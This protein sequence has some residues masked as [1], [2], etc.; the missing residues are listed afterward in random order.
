MTAH[1]APAAPGMDLPA[2]ITAAMT[3]ITGIW[4]EAGTVARLW[5]HDPDVW[6]GKDEA[7]WLGWLTVAHRQQDRPHRFAAL[8]GEIRSGDFSDAVVLGMGGSSLCPEVLAR[9]YPKAPGL[10]RLHVLDSTDPAQVAAMRQRVDLA[11][12]LFFVSSKSGTTL[13]PNIFADYF[14]DQV[15]AVVGE[16]EAARRFAAITDPGS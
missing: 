4:R 10:P 5:A 16:P 3:T 14:Y 11:H 9:T 7:R 13:E 2:G 8:A 1:V 15:R 12:T 6:T